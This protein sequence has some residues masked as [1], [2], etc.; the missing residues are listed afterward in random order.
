MKWNWRLGKW[1]GIN[2]HLHV[3]FIVFLGALILWGILTGEPA[4]LGQ[5]LTI[6][7]GVFLLAI[8]HEGAHA[9]VASRFGIKTL[10]MILLPFAGASRYEQRPSN[11]FQAFCI[12]VAGPFINILLGSV[13]FVVLCFRGAEPVQLAGQIVI[14][15]LVWLAYPIAGGAGTP[16]GAGVEMMEL[17]LLFGLINLL[18]AYP[19]DGGPALRAFLTAIMPAQ[20]ATRV[21]ARTASFIAWMIIIIGI[22]TQN[23][24]IAA[25]GFFIFL[26]GRQEA[27]VATAR[28]M[29][30]GLEVRA[31]MTTQ[32][33]KI[34]R[35]HV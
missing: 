14:D 12:A 2:V 28:L 34:G 17:S 26:S 20:R 19:L 13:L 31:A 22:L 8:L 7:G 21:A 1:F 25:L 11:P 15:W 24:L 29:L 10:D 23:Y 5:V 35:A 33:L 3:T 6:S 16:A 4:Q 27:A 30:E 9:L 18:P 32:Y